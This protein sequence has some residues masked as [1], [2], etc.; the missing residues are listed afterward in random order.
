MP[1]KKTFLLL[2][3]VELASGEDAVSL[4]QLL[5]ATESPEAKVVS[6]T[7][8]Y[9]KLKVKELAE[10]EMDKYFTEA[11]RHLGAVNVS[12]ERK[13]VLKGFAE[14]LMVREV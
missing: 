13:L 7:A 9:Q 12:E 2:K 10:A 14:K 11:M 5:T 8:I 1:T 3:C 6:V 4:Q